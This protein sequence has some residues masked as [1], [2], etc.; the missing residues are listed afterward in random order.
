MSRPAFSHHLVSVD[1]S[2]CSLC[3]FVLH[4]PRAHRPRRSLTYS[5]PSRSPPHRLANDVYPSPAHHR[6]RV[7]PSFRSRVSPHPTTAHRSARIG[8]L[9]F[10]DSIW[11][12]SALS[13]SI[14]LCRFLSPLLAA[15]SICM[16]AR[17]RFASTVQVVYI[18]TPSGSRSHLYRTRNGVEIYRSNK[19][20]HGTSRRGGEQSERYLKQSEIWIQLR[21]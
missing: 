16:I 14:R 8:L 19:C 4:R 6:L 13:T 17:G 1:P 2:S 18:F 20:I 21:A 3:I 15:L 12:S 5:A 9:P 7:P 10:H 11:I